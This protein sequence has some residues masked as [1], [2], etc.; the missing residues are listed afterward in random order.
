M[1]IKGIETPNESNEPYCGHLK[2]NWKRKTRMMEIKGQRFEKRQNH[3]MTLDKYLAWNLGFGTLG[4]S[5]GASKGLAP[6]HFVHFV[7]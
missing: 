2:M 4:D 5:H 7:S 3:D 1:D 6:T